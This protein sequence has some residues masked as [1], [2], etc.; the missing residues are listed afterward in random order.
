MGIYGAQKA[1]HERFRG[2]DLGFRL[3]ALGL[4]VRA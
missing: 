1:V 4:R 3:R 2:K